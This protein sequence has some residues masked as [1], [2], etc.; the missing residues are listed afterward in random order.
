LGEG[1]TTPRRKELAPYE[2]LV[3][4]WKHGD[5]PSDSIKGGEFLT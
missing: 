1:L 4:N 5:E 3:G 2:E